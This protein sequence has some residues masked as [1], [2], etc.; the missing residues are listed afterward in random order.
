MSIDILEIFNVQK[1]A[2]VRRRTVFGV[3]QSLFRL[4]A[5]AAQALGFTAPR[6]Y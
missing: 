4:Q 1:S 3:P 2:L 5:A 6:F